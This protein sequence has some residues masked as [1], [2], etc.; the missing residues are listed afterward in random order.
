MDHIMKSV[1]SMDTAVKPGTGVSVPARDN[2]QATALKTGTATP[3]PPAAAP[4][5]G[6]ASSAWWDHIRSLDHYAPAYPYDPRHV[7]GPDWTDDDAYGRD[8][9]MSSRSDA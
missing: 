2:G 8:G 9:A 5:G 4:N 3:L 6:T 1:P 7:Y